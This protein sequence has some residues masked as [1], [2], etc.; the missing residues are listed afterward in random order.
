MSSLDFYSSFLTQDFTYVES[1]SIV[2]IVTFLR[3][4][5]LMPFTSSR[6]SVGSIVC[7]IKSNLVS[8]ENKTV[9]HWPLCLIP[10]WTSHHSPHKPSPFVPIAMLFHSF[11]N[12][13]YLSHLSHLFSRRQNRL[14][15]EAFL[16]ALRQDYFLLPL[17]FLALY[18]LPAA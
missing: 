5:L 17:C 16:V 7:G 9:T 15:R 8:T 3:T 13:Q 4:N 2:I 12:W 14:F 11:S 10:T 18:F 6:I 1:T